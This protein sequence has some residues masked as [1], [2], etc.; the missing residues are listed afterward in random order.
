MLTYKIKALHIKYI[1]LVFT[2]ISVLYGTSYQQFKYFNPD[3]PKGLTDTI[4]YLEMAQ[5]NYNVSSVHKYRAVIPSL[6]RTIYNTINT[7]NKNSVELLKLSF[8]FV[9]FLFIFLAAYFL[10]FILETLGFKFILSLLGT[11][12]FLSSRD[13][14][15]STGI[16]LTDS[17]FLFSISFIIYCCLKK[18]VNILTFCMPVLLILKE[19]SLPF[20]L[21]PLRYKEFRK[22]KYVFSIILSVIIFLLF[23][24][25]IDYLYPSIAGQTDFFGIVNSH[26]HVIKKHFIHIFTLRGMHDIFHGFLLLYP[27]AGIG[28]YIN[29]K[30]KLYNIPIWLYLCIPIAFGFSLLSGNLGRMFFCSY[31]II[32]PGILIVISH[33][34]LSDNSSDV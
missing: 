13:V 11:V 3:N 1:F 7:S 15:I 12:L 6:S 20:L 24:K 26:I 34:S 31:P 16:P 17:G 27:I 2:I 23:R 30:Q 10:F 22:F 14:V 9:N 25:Y 8:Y 21:L 32:I 18:K 4:S 19:T 28:F 33:I 29:Y 5:G